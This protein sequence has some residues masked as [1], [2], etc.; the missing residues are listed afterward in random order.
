MSFPFENE[1]AVKPM[2][3]VDGQSANVGKAV[4]MIRRQ[5]IVVMFLSLREVCRVRLLSILDVR[6]VVGLGVQHIGE[7]AIVA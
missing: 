5:S 4:S 7:Y 6:K 3:Q 2:Y 1:V